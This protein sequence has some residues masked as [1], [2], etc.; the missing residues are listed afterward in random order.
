MNIINKIIKQIKVIISKAFENNN[1]TPQIIY[2]QP[3]TTPST[4][5][6]LTKSSTNCLKPNQRTKKDLADWIKSFNHTHFLTVQLPKN[7]KTSNFEASKEH[8]R[9]IMAKFEYCLLD[10]YW[11]KNHLPFICFAEKGRSD[12]WHYHILFN[13]GIWTTEHLQKTLDETTTSLRLPQYSLNLEPI[14]TIKDY[15]NFYCIKE[16]RIK[17]NG[18]FYSDRIILSGDLFAIATKTPFRPQ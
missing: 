7:L 9:K 2:S 5:K 11:N 8:L 18:Y 10:R 17:E 16:I 4:Q 6:C 1:H 13:A 14:N 12:G 3:L 15:T